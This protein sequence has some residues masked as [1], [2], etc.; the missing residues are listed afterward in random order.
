MSNQGLGRGKPRGGIG[1][2]DTLLNCGRIM[3]RGAY[4]KRVEQ[5]GVLNVLNRK[6]KPRIRSTS[7]YG[8]HVNPLR[9]ASQRAF[10]I[11]IRSN[12]G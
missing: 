7:K 9:S 2:D 5:Y 10:E 6:N 1:T 8:C 4:N 3:L 11:P 12:S